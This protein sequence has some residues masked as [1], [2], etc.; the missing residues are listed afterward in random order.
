MDQIK[1]LGYSIITLSL[2][3]A[4]EQLVESTY[5]LKTLLKITLF[6]IVP[7]YYMLRE[8]HRNVLW[9]GQKSLYHGIQFGVGAFLIIQLLSYLL[10]FLID[11]SAI[12]TSLLS[13]GITFKNF[14]IVGLYITFVN[15]FLE[16]YFFRGWLFLYLKKHRSTNKSAIISSALFAI[17]HVGI[18]LTW[19]NHWLLLGLVLALFF[20]G[21]FF[22]WLD[23]KSGSI[24]SSWM[25]HI[26][27]DA[28]IIVIGLR[29][30]W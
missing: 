21:M 13:N 17:Y 30:L 19:F 7:G 26:L 25:V 8:L 15:S 4:I 16:E 9:G 12:T 10:S 2:L 6:L 3:F 28:A 24:L 23:N 22:C 1:I 29:L 11:Y 5:L 20:V 18:F 14:I 27:A